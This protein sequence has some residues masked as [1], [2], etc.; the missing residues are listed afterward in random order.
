MRTLAAAS[1]TAL[2]TGCSSA[3]TPA[4]EAAVAENLTYES[5]EITTENDRKAAPEFAAKD[6]AGATVKVADY[7]GKVLLLNFWATW[8]VPCK[9]EMPWF[10]E[11][12]R[13]YK[14]R[15]FA[16]VGAS[17]D[18]N[19]WDVVKPYIDEHKINYRIIL[20]SPEM[21]QLYEVLDALPMTFM[22]DR[23]GRVAAIHH[24]LVSKATYLKQIEQ[25]LETKNA[26]TRG[27]E[28]AS[29]KLTDFRTN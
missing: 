21:T 29:G 11:F 16:V 7:K 27:T 4:P 6:A 9:A 20:A 3:P 22:I 24:G 17:L 15:G 8:C 5:P 10:Q 14:D 12:E 2:L 23:E 26:A 18:S 1:F 19:G 28:L 13:S 25:L